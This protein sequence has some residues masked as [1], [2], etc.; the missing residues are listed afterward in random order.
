ME[1][2]IASTYT[3]F[4]DEGDSRAKTMGGNPVEKLWVFPGD[5]IVWINT[6]PKIMTVEFKNKS[7]FGLKNLMID[8]GNRSVT[9]VKKQKP[10]TFEY[11]VMPNAAQSG[12]LQTRIIDGTPKGIIGDEP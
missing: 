8:A 11:T 4:I 7:I 6:A 9:T 10:G 3:V 1:K 12:P 5:Q 2:K